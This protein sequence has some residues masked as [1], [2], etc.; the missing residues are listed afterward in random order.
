MN[1]FFP[2]DLAVVPI[3]VGPL[4]VL[5]AM[6]PAILLGLGSALLALFKPRTF[7]LALRILWR[8]KL[9]VLLYDRDD[10]KASH[11]DYTLGW[12]FSPKGANFKDTTGGKTLLLAK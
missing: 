12:S 2:T 10:P 8:L 7:K 5:L 4:Q 11:A 1:A 3:L 6:L 9:S